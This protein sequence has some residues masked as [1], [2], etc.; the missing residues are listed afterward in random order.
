HFA[1][2][3]ISSISISSLLRQFRRLLPRQPY[4]EVV[5]PGSPPVRRC[6]LARRGS[7]Q[8]QRSSHHE[9]LP[10]KPWSPCLPTRQH[11]F[12]HLSTGRI[13]SPPPGRRSYSLL[14]RAAPNGR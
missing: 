1:R 13:V 6:F 12:A 5:L 7:S 3:K 8:P 2:R 11:P 9:C 14:R 4:P 10:P